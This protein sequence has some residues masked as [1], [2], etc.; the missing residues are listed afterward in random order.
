MEYYSNLG[1]GLSIRLHC[2]IHK[3]LSFSTVLMFAK[4]LNASNLR[5]K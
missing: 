4:Q 1:N 5:K 3:K 2:V